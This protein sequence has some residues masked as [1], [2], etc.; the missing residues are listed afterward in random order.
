MW[1]SHCSER[2]EGATEKADRKTSKIMAIRMEGT[3]LSLRF[4]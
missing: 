3:T 2:L 4:K 1:S